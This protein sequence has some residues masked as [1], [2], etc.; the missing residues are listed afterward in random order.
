VA[1]TCRGFQTNRGTGGADPGWQQ[2]CG[3]AQRTRD[4]DAAIVGSYLA[5]AKPAQPDGT[6]TAARV[7]GT[8]KSAVSRI[9]A[10]AQGF[11]LHVRMAQPPCRS[12]PRLSVAEKGQNGWSR[13]N[14]PQRKRRP[15]G[16]G[17]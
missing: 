11:H 6:E 17:G 10:P 4:V 3:A 1:P 12:S 9:V 14:W 2:I 13:C 15:L 7:S 16:A 5:G 8:S